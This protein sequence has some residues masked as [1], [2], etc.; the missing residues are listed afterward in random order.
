M[1][2]FLDRFKGFRLALT[3]LTILPSGRSEWTEENARNAFFYFPAVGAIIGVL[4]AGSVLPTA[5]VLDLPS[6]ITAFLSLAIFI[7][8]SGG[9]HLDGW[10]DVSDAVGSWKNRQKRIEILKDSQVGA[11]AVWSV[12]LLL[13]GKFVF[14]LYVIEESSTAWLLFIIIPLLS[15]FVMA[16]LLMGAPLLKKEGLAAWFQKRVKRHDRLIIMG[17]TGLLLFILHFSTA[18]YWIGLLLLGTAIFLLSV[19]KRIFIKLFGGVNGDM[20]GALS[21]GTEVLLWLMS[22][23]YISFVTG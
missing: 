3:F 20:A 12:L 13:L 18:T 9:I 5:F 4:T 1:K 14:I 22:V 11:A 15:R 21:E 23:L 17:S 8:M 2:A 10:M 6:Y 16:L 7:I 19:L